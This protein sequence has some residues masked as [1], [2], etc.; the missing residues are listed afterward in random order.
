MRV[1]VREVATEQAR[2]RH[3]QNIRS[4]NRRGDSLDER[5]TK[6]ESGWETENDASE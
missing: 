5:A 6:P 3:E 2:N 1:D 4:R